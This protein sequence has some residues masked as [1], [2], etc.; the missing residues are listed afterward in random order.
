MAWHS[1]EEG[2]EHYHVCENCPASKQI[3]SDNRVDGDGGLQL[4]GHCEDYRTS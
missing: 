1:N 3:H 2:I 4:C